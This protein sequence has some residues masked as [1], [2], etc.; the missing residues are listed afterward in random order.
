M[1]GIIHQSGREVRPQAPLQN[2]PDITLYQL[3][4]IPFSEISEEPMYAEYARHELPDWNT[5]CAGHFGPEVRA[6]EQNHSGFIHL[7]PGW[8]AAATHR[9]FLENHGPFFPYIIRN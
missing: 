9:C 5:C 6:T 1:D 3:D 7:L 8:M 2:Y 4:F